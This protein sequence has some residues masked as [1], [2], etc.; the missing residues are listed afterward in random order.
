MDLVPLFP[1]SKREED[2]GAVEL[3]LFVFAGFF[4][5]V[6]F[7]LFVL[8]YILHVFVFWTVFMI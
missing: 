7:V 4:C 8:F 5:F 6:L 3:Y 2:T 1:G